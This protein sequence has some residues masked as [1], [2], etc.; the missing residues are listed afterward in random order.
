M[1]I[2]E[3]DEHAHSTPG[4]STN[5]EWHKL[6]THCQS[7]YATPGIS[8]VGFIRFNPD[9]WKVDG[10]AARYPFKTKL[11]DLGN[12]I[13]QIQNDTSKELQVYHMFYPC[14]DTKDIIFKSSK[15]EMTSAAPV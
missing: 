14:D 7:A 2:V 10:K 4:Y 11:N 9:S 1:I 8:R 12:L 15:G 5:C 3:T 13:T 6:L